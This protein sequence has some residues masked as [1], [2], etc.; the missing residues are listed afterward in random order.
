MT[1]KRRATGEPG[2]RPGDDAQ[3]SGVGPVDPTQPLGSRR[4]RRL[5]RRARRRRLGRLGTAAV[6]VGLLIVAAAIGFGVNRIATGGKSSNAHAQTTLL[7]QVTGSNG[8][9]T[10]AV[11]LG[12]DE[13]AANSGVELL[14][15]ASLITSVCGFGQQSFGQV[16]TLPGGAAAA[17]GALSRDLD[18]IRIDGAW[19]LTT[20]QLAALVNAVGGVTVNVD[21]QVTQ[22]GPHGTT[23]VVTPAGM[24]HLNGAQAAAF[25]TF[26][27]SNS[28]AAAAQLAR[29]QSVVQAVIDKLPSSSSSVA[30]LIGRLGTGATSSLGPDRLATLLLGLAADDKKSGG[31]LAEDL[32]VTQLPTGGSPTYQIDQ[33]GADK[34][35]HT[36]FKDSLPRGGGTPLTVQV[37]DGTAAPGVV[38]AACE[39]L[40][41]AGM[42]PSGGDSPTTDNG[43]SQIYV[44]DRTVASAQQGYRVADALKLPHGDVAV[45]PVGQN[46]AQVLVVLGRDYKP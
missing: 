22:P 2:G 24:Q 39:Q 6:A 32:P 7:L 4:L 11:L 9:S 21:V 34:A 38:S 15:P 26:R 16:L 29:L 40:I 33:S 36:L 1:G 13:T 8:D 20:A 23:A 46:V 35:A 45:N 37:Q 27:A 18:G 17:A 25:A 10:G 31:V 43:A 5:E 44:T 28:E 3:A 19:T 12:H 41:E 42:N 30:S 14:V